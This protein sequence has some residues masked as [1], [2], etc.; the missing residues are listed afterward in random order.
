MNSIDQRIGA[1]CGLVFIALFGAGLAI[2]GW[3]PL[4]GPSMTA[5]QVAAMYQSHN[6]QIRVGMFVM[7]FAAAFFFALTAVTSHQLMRIQGASRMPAYLQMIAGTANAVTFFLAPVLFAVAAFRPDR[8]QDVLYALN[9]LAWLVFIV[10][11]SAAVFQTLS[12]A[13]GVM[14]DRSPKPVF[15]HW[16]G[17]LSI[18]AALMF[19][20]TILP[21]FFK[22]GPFAWNG[23]FGFYI[24]ATAF[25]V[26]IVSLV[27]VLLRA[28]NDEHF[29]SAQPLLQSAK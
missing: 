28:I 11:G 12:M 8:N 4:P 10:P 27:V 5:A 15:P 2:A 1:W 17:Y 3:L 14:I 24:G 29:A 7:V 13:L 19:V 26:W 6:V 21:M 16:F 20:P 9:D 22:T 25:F 23:L 18:W